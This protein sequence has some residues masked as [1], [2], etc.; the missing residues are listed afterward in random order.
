M[1][2]WLEKEKRKDQVEVDSSKRKII[3]E[4][5]SLDKKELFHKEEERKITLWTKLKTILW[6][7]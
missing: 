6:G 4:L 5:K 3:Q 2:K 1:L 7:N